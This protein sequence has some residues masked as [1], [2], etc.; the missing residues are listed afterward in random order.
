M[1]KEKIGGTN[2]SRESKNDVSAVKVNKVVGTGEKK[3]IVN[4]PSKSSDQRKS[5][6]E[7]ES[8]GRSRSTYPKT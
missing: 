2:I 1:K 8:V 3:A 7:T 4:S 6:G 5:Q